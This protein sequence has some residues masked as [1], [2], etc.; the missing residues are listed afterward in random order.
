VDTS[1]LCSDSRYEA[2]IPIAI[3]GLIVFPIGIPLFFLV[4]LLR[5]QSRMNE[6]EV[7][8]WLGLLS[9]AYTKPMALFELLDMAVKLL[10]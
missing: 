5:F 9:A 7:V 8:R 4:L 3:V 2:Y 1:L 10:L 6:P